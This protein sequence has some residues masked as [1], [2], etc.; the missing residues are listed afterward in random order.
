M[1]GGTTF[2]FVT[3]GIHAALEQSDVVNASENTHALD[4]LLQDSAEELVT[5][6]RTRVVVEKTEID[7]LLINP[8]T[9]AVDKAAAAVGA[10]WR[11]IY[12]DFEVADAI[13]RE[14]GRRHVIF[15][16]LG[17]AEALASAREL[18]SP[19]MAEQVVMS[20]DD[21]DRLIAY[22]LGL[23]HALNIAFFTAL[24]ESGE[25]AP[26]LARMS[27]TTFDSQL[28]VATRRPQDLVDPRNH[29][30]EIHAVWIFGTQLFQRHAIGPLPEAITP[31]RHPDREIDNPIG[32]AHL[33]GFHDVCRGYAVPSSSVG[34]QDVVV[35]RNVHLGRGHTR[36]DGTEPDQDLPLLRTIVAREQGR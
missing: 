27:S 22:V 4:Q 30:A 1:K 14:F 8:Q 31:G 19:T 20:L 13:N 9:T 16:D 34:K 32:A 36:E 15:V 28:D 3:D 35:R 12:N 23:S 29:R 25:A 18:F 26:K 6:V 21:H 17:H 24:A 2:H 5:L 10:R 33:G 11:V 7:G